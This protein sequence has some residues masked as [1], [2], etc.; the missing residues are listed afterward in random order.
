M[1]SESVAT[2]MET[3]ARVQS[4]GRAR[5]ALWL[6]TAASTGGV[7]MGLELLGFRLYAPYFGYSVY[8]WGSLIAVVM[9]ALAGGYAIGGWLSDRSADDTPLYLTILASGIYQLIIV[10]AAGWL[11]R[12]LWNDGVFSGTIIA[13][14]IIFAPP[15]TALAET[16]PF[17]IR[18]LARA[19]HVGSSAGKVYALSTVGSIVGVLATSFLLIPDLGTHATLQILCAISIGAGLAGLL[20]RRRA[21]LLGVLALVLLAAARQPKLR[22]FEIWR[23]ESVY[24]QVRVIHYKGY[25]WLALN[26][27]RH[28]HTTFKDNSVWS[29]SYQ[30]VFALG[31]VFVHQPHLLVLGMGAGGSIRMT[32][33]ADPN[34][35]VDAVEIDPLVVEA[36][37]RFFGLPRRARWLHVHIADARPWLAHDHTTYN[38]VHIDLY[39]GGPYIPFYLVTKEFFRLV[40]DHMTLDGLLMMNVY[41][42]GPKHE[43]LY[44]TV[45]TLRRVFPS[46]FVYSRLPKS[47]MVFAFAA[48]KSMSSVRGVLQ[49]ASGNPGV[50]Q[51]ALAAASRI[52]DVTPPPDTVVFT[53]DRAP[54]DPMTRRM[55]IADR[56]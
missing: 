6:L 48:E 31:P 39:Q 38:L 17:V 56:R 50:I 53:D 55:L 24:N 54:I 5:V 49:Q 26:D 11:L 42:A 8:V 46:V 15:M 25:L 41:D 23:G 43:I 20:A 18:L 28:S 35:Q 7:I 21:V 19:G 45:A 10:Y 52:R 47:Y 37:H 3:P 29:G 13:T 16:S 12:S 44:S 33:V 27:L 1:P 51:I 4:P 40:R 36:A 14:L 22:Y 34:I 2:N 30:D 9:A 32:R